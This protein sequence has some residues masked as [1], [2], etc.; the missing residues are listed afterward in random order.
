[1]SVMPSS[2]RIGI[3]ER[4]DAS[5]HY[6]WA[7]HLDAGRVAMAILITKRLT[8]RF[9]DEVAA[10][11]GKVVVHA[12]CT[13]W[14]GTVIEPRGPDVAWTRAQFDK[15]AAVL[16]PEQIVLRVDPV[17]P[18]PEG[19]ARA[20]GVL[21]AFAESSV[22]RVRYSVLDM[23]PHVAARFAAAGIAHPYQGRFQ[24]SATQQE[25][26]RRQFLGYADRYSFESCAEAG[27]WQLGCVSDRDTAACNAA[28]DLGGRSGQ[29]A[30]CLC[31]A[32]KTE[33]LTSRRPA[34]CSHGCL[35]CYW[36]GDPS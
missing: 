32:A 22:Q 23:Y 18:T 35:Y 4:G 13:G 11:A 34:P 5:L 20:R 26:V 7:E 14:G 16:A 27:P 36:K 31:P 9:I 17:V 12:T 2:S 29:R 30:A 24:A 25:V 1:M 33:L 21:D 3:T 15:L 28:I 19:I 6:D 8:D 10:R